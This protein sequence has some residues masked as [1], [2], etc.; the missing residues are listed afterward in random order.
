M[1]LV[2]WNPYRSWSLINRELENLFEDFAFPRPRRAGREGGDDVWYPAMDMKENQNNYMLRAELPGVSKENINVSV[3]ED[4]LTISGEKKAEEDV[5][6]GG[7]HRSERVYGNFTR[8]FRMPGPVDAERI[9]AEFK[10]GVLQLT[11]PKSA[12]AKPKAIQIK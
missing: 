1:N 7:W 11:L 5:K 9:Q 4:V 12:A 2:K 6:E 3:A 8:S 10:D